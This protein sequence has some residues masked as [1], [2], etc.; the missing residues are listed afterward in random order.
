[1]NIYV[2]FEK[3]LTLIHIF[4][5]FCNSSFI[6]R[7]LMVKISQMF[8][9]LVQLSSILAEWTSIEE[10]WKK[11]RNIGEILT[12]K[13]HEMNDELQNGRKSLICV[14]CPS[15]IIVHIIIF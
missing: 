15:N 3:Y 14:I 8:T 12:I 11:I 2:V 5:A 13:E 7:S 1:M 6:S 10:S 9:V 4:R